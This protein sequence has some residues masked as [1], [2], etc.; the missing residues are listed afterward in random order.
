[1]PRSWYLSWI[2]KFKYLAGLEAH[3]LKAPSLRAPG[4]NKTVLAVAVAVAAAAATA[5][6]AFT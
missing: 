4:S 5:V 2:P 1:M 6:A 3:G